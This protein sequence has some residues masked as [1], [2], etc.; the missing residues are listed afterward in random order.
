MEINYMH[1]GPVIVDT[2]PL[3]PT[4]IAVY[5]EDRSIWMQLRKMK[6]FRFMSDYRSKERG[7]FAW[8]CV[9]PSNLRSTVVKMSPQKVE[10]P[11]V[12]AQRVTESGQRKRARSYSR[13][14]S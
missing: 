13:L 4:E 7:Q 9:L 1:V 6:G 14:R 3:G 11:P 2:W 10:K 12:V 8:Q 5:T